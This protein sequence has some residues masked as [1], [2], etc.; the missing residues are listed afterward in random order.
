MSRAERRQYQRMMKGQDPYAQPSRGGSRKPPRRTGPREPRDW[1][2][3]RGFWLKS[4]GIAAVVGLV[5]LSVVWP[6]G[7]ERALL[8]GAITAVA[9]IAVLV[10]VRLLLQRRTAPR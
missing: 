2:F 3:H 6:G 10:V 5:G 1:S 4:I 7:A 9:T 8:V